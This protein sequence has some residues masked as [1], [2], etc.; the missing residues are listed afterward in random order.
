MGLKEASLDSPSFRSGFTHFAEQLELIEKWLSGY[1][2][3]ILKLTHEVGPFESAINGFLNQTV[4]PL[5]VSEALLD[6]DYT[7]ITVK[8]C[9]EQA[10]D[11]WA[12]TLSSIKQMEAHMVDP[13]KTFIHGELQGF[14]EIKR[15]VESYQ[16]QLDGLQARFASQTRAKEPSSLREDAFQL[17]TARKAYLKVCLDFSVAAPQLR[18][19]LDKLLVKIFSDQWH[20][21]RDPQLNMNR[22][23]AKWGAEVDRVRSWSRELENGERAFR[24]ELSNARK[25]IEEF[26]ENAVRP[27]RDLE[28]YALE[29]PTKQRGPSMSTAQLAGNAEQQGR[30]EK[31][32]WLMLRTVVGKPSRTVWV[33]RWFYVKDG[34]FGWLVQGSRSGA[35]EESDR[36]GVLLCNIKSADSDDRRHVFSISTKDTTFVVQAETQPELSQWLSAF[37]MAKQK[38]LEKPASAERQVDL[39]FTVSPPSAP[40]FAASVADATTFP[41]PDDPTATIGVDRSATLPV[42]GVDAGATRNSFDVNATRRS[43][44][45]DKDAE[46]SRDRIISKLDF[47]KRS[48]GG[49]NSPASPGLAGGGISSLIMASHGSMPVG[50]GALPVPAAETRKISSHLAA[51][52]DMPLNSLAPSTL[53]NPPAPTNLSA[54]AVIVNGDRGNGLGHPDSLGVP[55]GLLANVWGSSNWGFLNRLERGEV[56]DGL[57]SRNGNFNAHRENNPPIASPNMQGLPLVD[58]QGHRKTVSLDGGDIF[59]PSTPRSF[60]SE[61][62]NYYPAQLKMQDAQFRLLFPNISYDERVVLVFKASW[63]PNDQQEFPGRIYVTS[64]DTYFYS[65]HCGMTMTTSIPLKS[66][67]DVTAAS[68]RDWD[69]IFLHLHEGTDNTGLT[70]I[71]IKTF[72]EPLKLLQR[73][74]N[75]LVKN[76]S[77]EP[78]LPLDEIMKKLIMA[79]SDNAGGNR[80][81]NSIENLSVSDNVDSKSSFNPKQAGALR[82]N[83]LIGQDLYGHVAGAKGV[84]KSKSFKLPKQ[85]VVFIPSNMEQVVVEKEF[86]VSPKALYHVLF[87]DRSAV[88]QLLYHE[89]QASRKYHPC[90]TPK[91]C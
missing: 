88:W 27:S 14:K 82:T 77:E 1:Y 54:T 47:H 78:M 63:K 76:A 3:C 2:R 58:P 51:L 70:R 34:I 49:L 4:P 60:V 18:M 28:D 57:E 91:R 16:K 30:A 7:A 85:P 69:A 40:E 46:S 17:F 61:Y 13:I 80:S 65:N 42:P 45:L 9:G 29:A 66:I 38:A 67:A 12:A 5:Y 55:S 71:M 87:G 36:I 23:I 75:I 8:R 74:L 72:L 81:D 39:A 20:D 11:F 24:N 25:Q 44:G 19:N 68:G 84:A 31:Q 32:G 79:E 43:S 50:P 48:T 15:N 64:H 56:A 52:R 21:V 22:S 59:R 10:R 89:R 37:Q 83:V 26:A 41:I 6:H 33:R 73:R 90:M 53:T 86:N 62:P 35:V